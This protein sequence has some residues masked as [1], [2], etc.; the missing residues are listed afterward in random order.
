MKSFLVAAVFLAALGGAAHAEE[1]DD[2]RE[3]IKAEAETFNARMYAGEPGN[4]AY[5]CF[6]RRYDAEHLAHHPKQK[7]ASMK[8]LISAEMDTEDKQFHNSFRL[9]FRY[10]HRSG[11]FDSSGS[12]HHAVF[13]KDGTEIRL[14][15]GVDCEGGGIGVALSKDDKSAIVR[16]ARVR[17]WQNNKPDDDAELSL[18]AGADDGIFRL[19]RT[20]NK[21]CASLVTDRKE[22]A[23][24]RH[25]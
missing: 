5:A 14:G 4:K 16:L 9:G 19:D 25:K 24:L 7:V 15:C 10:R 6:V 18:V 3:A 22:L 20:D 2:I 13:T 8:L 21:E 12:C 1:A 23:A 11:D 17:V